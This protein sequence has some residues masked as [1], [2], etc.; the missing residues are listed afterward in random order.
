MN[1]A[2]GATSPVLVI[3]STGVVLE[4]QWRRLYSFSSCLHNT[5]V[6]NF[7]K[8]QLFVVKSYLTLTQQN[9]KPSLQIALVQETETE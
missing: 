7:K 3:I 9:G 2:Y 1:P 4:H 8:I 5:N 6:E